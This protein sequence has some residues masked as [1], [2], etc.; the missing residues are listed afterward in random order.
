MPSC[1][2]PVL[3]LESDIERESV[4]RKSVTDNLLVAVLHTCLGSCTTVCCLVEEL[5]VLSVTCILETT[6]A[7]DLST[8]IETEEIVT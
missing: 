3:I 1:P 7:T 4:L 5:S 2:I 8:F 6:E